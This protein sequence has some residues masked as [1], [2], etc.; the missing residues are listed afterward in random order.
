MGTVAARQNLRA[1]SVR[2]PETLYI[3][4]HKVAERKNLSI[5]A[6]IGEALAGV[7]DQAHDQEMYEAAT[8]LGLDAEMSSVDF[9]F[10]AQAEAALAN[11]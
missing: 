4:A 9:A 1:F 5:N 11:G 6:L 7:V 3:E 8:L 2:V 10:G